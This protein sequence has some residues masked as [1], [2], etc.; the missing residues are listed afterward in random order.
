[1]GK[2]NCKQ[3]SEFSVEGRFL[4]F[5]FENGYKKYLR[6]ATSEGE[7]S[8]KLCKD[9]RA[10]RNLCL[11][12]SDWIQVVGEK[13]L[14]LKSGKLKL[15]AEQVVIVTVPCPAP[16]SLSVEAISTKTKV[17]ILVCQKSDCMKRGGKAVCQALEVGLSARGMEDRVV[18]RGTGCMKKCSSG[19]N[20]VMP[21]KSR[22]SRVT[23]GQ[24]PG[25]L[26]KHFVKSESQVTQEV[27]LAESVKVP[28]EGFA[29]SCF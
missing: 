21:D 11:H 7:Y 1:M 3:V 25:L 28:T 6:L 20:L 27:Y 23:P 14:D 29:D 5:G 24:I 19:P 9:L 18:V 10:S 2:F 8:I 13:K 12:P 26:D 4:G 16:A 17:S 15:K 22:Y